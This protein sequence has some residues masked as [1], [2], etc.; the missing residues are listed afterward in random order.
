MPNASLSFLSPVGR[1][2]LA[3]LF[4]MAGPG[5]LMTPEATAG[6][7]ASG[8]LPGSA[9]LAMA[10][11]L[12]EVLGGLALLFGFKVRWA[13]FALAA[14]TLLASFMF[15][16]YWSAPAEQQFMQQLLF[17]KNMAVVGA[18]L[19]LTAVGAGPW[20]LDSRLDEATESPQG[21]LAR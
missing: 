6:Y 21:T 2:L 18:L 20:S 10:V 8:G 12:L 5:K 16:N 17:S 14:F 13:A 9:M 3:S 11:G 19:F 7:M 15:H 4:L 1:L